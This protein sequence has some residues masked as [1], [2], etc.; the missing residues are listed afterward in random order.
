LR[1][2][3]F[4]IV[5][6]N[7]KYHSENRNV[8]GFIEVEPQI[9]MEISNY[10]IEKNKLTKIK[11]YNDGQYLLKLFIKNNDIYIMDTLVLNIN[12]KKKIKE[13][14]YIIK[15]ASISVCTSNETENV[16]VRKIKDQGYGIPFEIIG[17]CN[18]KYELKDGYGLYEFRY[19]V[20]GTDFL[21]KKEDSVLEPYQYIDLNINQ[22]FINCMKYYNDK[23]FNF[24]YSECESV[25]TTDYFYCDAQNMI[26]QM[27][28]KSHD[29]VSA[30]LFKKDLL[31]GDYC[32]YNLD[33]YLN[34]LDIFKNFEDS[35]WH[36]F[37]QNDISI[38]TNILN[39]IENTYQYI[40]SHILLYASNI[41]ASKMK[42]NQL[43]V[44]E[45]L[46]NG[47]KISY[48]NN[49]NSLSVTKIQKYKLMNHLLNKKIEDFLC[50]VEK[51]DRR[52]YA[53]IKNN[54]LVE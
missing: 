48:K 37:E 47:L 20:S 5:K 23:N 9:E 32:D 51:K 15:N 34:L 22:N 27:N 1:K 33:D 39:D 46:L 42:K 45:G 19:Y 4:K 44:L 3:N 6:L 18:T 25:P 8:N 12:M 31:N 17:D 2:T 11:F 49:I 43:Y 7:I 36:Y 29:M 53:S 38:L 26:I 14:N 54:Y 24:A 10:K 21:Y 35:D 16:I 30:F 40:N 52:K 13:I 28:E 41:K 50:F